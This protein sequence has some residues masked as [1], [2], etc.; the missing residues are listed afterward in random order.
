M[1]LILSFDSYEQGTDPVIDWLLHSNASF[2]KVSINDI[3]FGKNDC[4]LDISNGNLYIKGQKVNDLIHVVWFRRLINET[5]LIRDYQELHSLNL[6]T[7]MLSEVEIIFKFLVKIFEKKKWLPGFNGFYLNKLDELKIAKEIGLN[8]PKSILTNNKI[9]LLQFF[10][11]CSGNIITK[12]V[13]KKSYYKNENVIY[14]GLT[15]QLVFQEIELYDNCFFPSFFQ[16]KIE[17]EI[18]IRSFILNDKIYSTAILLNEGKTH[19]DMK[20]YTKSRKYH[21][22]PYKLPEEIQA[23][24]KEFLKQVELNT[25]SVDMIKS[26]DGKYYYLEVNP[27]GQY[28]HPSVNCN[29]YIEK[30]IA[31]WLIKNDHEE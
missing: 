21:Q 1:I 25:G 9:N 17:A 29:Y 2:I 4:L 22:L 13:G 11:K 23:Q 6:A 30:E 26:T 14:A 3:L 15:K 10:D 8:V 27:V 12:A 5:K 28:L 31:L 16:E 24:L 18:E 19:C 7:D 20:L